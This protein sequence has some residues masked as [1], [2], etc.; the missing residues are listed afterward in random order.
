MNCLIIDH[1]KDSVSSLTNLASRVKD[2][3]V[4]GEFTDALDAYYYLQKNEVDLLFLE[5]EMPGLNGIELAKLLL[6]RNM[7]IIFTTS[8]KDYAAEAFE[9][10]IAD[11]L[12]KPL[13]PTRFVQA[14]NRA[15]EIICQQ[16]AKIESTNSEYIF[17]R[18]SSVVRKLKLEDILWAEAMGDYVKFYTPGKL[19]AIHGTLKDAEQRLPQSRFIRVH[20]SYI[21]SV[22]KIDTMQ[23]GGIV[24][25]GQFLPVADAYK[26]VLSER[27]NIF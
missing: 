3:H 17:V 5:V 26:K 6:N 27:M 14:V 15:R 4:E 1:D 22:N 2:L 9:L 24:I 12:L 8:K 13:P 23:G 10:N 25:D 18:D 21:I 20:R 16:K 11:Y 19:Y 7:V